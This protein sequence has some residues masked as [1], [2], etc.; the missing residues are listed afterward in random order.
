MGPFIQHAN[1]SSD[2]IEI[3]VYAGQDGSF[4]LYEDEGDTYGY[5]QGQHAT[6]RVTWDDAAKELTIGAMAG[7]Y[8]GMLTTRTFNVVVV[9]PQHGSGVELATPDATVDYDGSEAVVSV[10]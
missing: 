3:R 8:P 1:E 9:G 6:I 7:N 2:P 5:E 4:T 10:P